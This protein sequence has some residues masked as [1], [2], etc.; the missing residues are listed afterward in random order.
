MLRVMIR[1]LP[2]S[3][4][5]QVGGVRGDALLVRVTPPPANGEATN[6]ALRALAKALGVHHREV[7]LLTG[8]SSR[9]KVVSVEGEAEMI[10]ARLTRLREAS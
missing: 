8:G 2:N 1:V 3:P 9:D 7:R 10:R 6:A 5:T 4:R